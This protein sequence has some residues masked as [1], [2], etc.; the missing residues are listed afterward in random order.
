M[1]NSNKKLS[2]DK[3]TA[4]K[5]EAP[6]KINLMLGVDNVSTEGLEEG[7]ILVRYSTDEPFPFFD[8]DNYETIA[9]QL[10]QDPSEVSLRRLNNKAPFHLDHVKTVRNVVGVVLEANET[11]AKIKFDLNSEDGKETYRKYAE[12]ILHHVSVGSE[13]LDKVPIGLGRF[14]GEDVKLYRVKHEPFEISAVSVP[15][16][17]EANLIAASAIQLNDIR[18]CQFKQNELDLELDKRNRDMPAELE[19]PDSTQTQS[20]I[21]NDKTYSEVELNKKAEEMASKQVEIELTRRASIKDYAVKLGI[22]ED[23][24]IYKAVLEN[25]QYSLNDVQ[26]AFYKERDKQSEIAD[27]TA[28]QQAPAQVGLSKVKEDIKLAK[29]TM[30]SII[31]TGKADGKFANLGFKEFVNEIC[32]DSEG[33]KKFNLAHY[34]D[35]RDVIELAHES[36]DFTKLLVESGERMLEDSIQETGATYNQVGRNREKI[37][38]KPMEILRTDRIAALEERTANSQFKRTTFGED[39]RVIKSKQLGRELAIDTDMLDNDDL[40]AFNDVAGALADAIQRTRNRNFYKVLGAYSFTE[41]GYTGN[42]DPNDADEMVNFLNNLG[43]RTEEDADGE[44]VTLNIPLAAIVTPRTQAGA[45]LKTVR[46]GINATSTTE[47]NAFQLLQGVDTK[48][49]TEPQLDLINVNNFYGI[50]PNN[51]RAAMEYRTKTG[52]ANGKINV[53]LDPRTLEIIHQGIDYFNPFVANEISM[54]KSTY[55]GV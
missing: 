7:E 49:I 31:A 47:L 14:D 12:G 24:E 43:L 28:S 44:K 36:K 16:L 21:S 23:S 11:T 27:I 17:A 45:L 25:K 3:L 8:W 42:F 2:L 13:I 48:I 6:N 18:H 37:D 38:T 34:A 39:S 5:E 35:Y 22:S 19:K 30:V 40:G 51:R 32:R 20:Q 29:E 26:L 4:N 33:N 54:V 41:S 50:G 1:P 55:A 53:Y 9:I 52:Y 46:A 10:S 15:M